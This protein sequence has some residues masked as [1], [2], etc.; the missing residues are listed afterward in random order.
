MKF[1]ALL[2]CAASSAFGSLIL[3]LTP[4]VGGQ[5]PGPV[6]V[7]FQGTLTDTDTDTSFLFLNDISVTFKGVGSSYLSLDPTGQPASSPNA[8]FFNTVPGDLIGDGQPVD[9]SYT[10]PVFEI[11]IAPNAPYGRYF[12]TLRILGGYNGPADLDVLASADFEVDATPEP[13]AWISAATGL[14]LVV[15]RRRR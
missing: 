12:G 15:W 6:P 1:F 9:N 8:F 11:F 3:Q 13:A 5:P 14:G 7:V 2:L 4:A 10:G